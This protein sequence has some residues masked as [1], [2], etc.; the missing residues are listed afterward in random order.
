MVCG[1]SALICTEMATRTTKDVDIVALLNSNG[2][3]ADPEPLPEELLDAASKVAEELN[4]PPDWVNNGPSSGPGGLFRMG[5]PAGLADRVMMRSFG[6]YLTVCFI[7]RIDQVFLKLYAAVDCG[8]YHT[9][10]LLSLNPT[11]NELLEAA[12]WTMTH[13]VSDGFRMVMTSFLMERGYESV[14]EKI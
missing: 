5:L 4:L 13:D 12:R 7:S 1:G 9:E 6:E 10:D 8:G 14:A 11:E 3:L 2:A